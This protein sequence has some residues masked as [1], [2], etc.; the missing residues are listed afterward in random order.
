MSRRQDHARGPSGVT[1]IVGRDRDSGVRVDEHPV[2]LVHATDR[3]DR[4]LVVD[5]HTVE[6]VSQLVVSGRLD[7]RSA[8]STEGVHDRP[9]SLRVAV[10]ELEEQPLEVAGH[11][12]VHA[13]A[14]RRLHVAGFK[15]TCP[16]SAVEDVVGVRPDDEP[17]DRQ[18]HATGDVSSEHVAE[19]P[20]GDDESDVAACV[21]ADC[22][23]GGD[24]VDDLGHH[25]RPVDRVDRRQRPSSGQCLVPEQRLHQVLAV[26]EGP[27]DGDVVHV[28]R[29]SRWSSDGAAL[30]RRARRDAG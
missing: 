20:G 28:R 8:R 12:D 29:W 3:L 15:N 2:G 6:D 27:P 17:D 10:V 30:P 25:P 16:Q 1:H 19:V 26:V 23:S 11:L 13:R 5:S 24:V 18:A 21:L 14:E 22:S 7:R 4:L 9:Q